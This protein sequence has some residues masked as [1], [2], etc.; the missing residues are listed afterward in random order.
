MAAQPQLDAAGGPRK[1]R[2]IGFLLVLFLFP[3][4]GFA[5]DHSVEQTRLAA[6]QSAFDAGHWD[7]AARLSRGPADQSTEFDFLQGLAL[8]R[9]EKWDD[10]K[11]AFETGAR[12]SPRD[13]RFPVE[14][15]GIAYKQKDFRTAKNRL[16]AV[17][18]LNPRDAYAR[19]F[20]ATIYFLEGNL[21]AALKYWNPEDKP[22]LR[23]VAFAPFLQLNESLRNRALAFNAPQILT[24]DALLTTES[25][26]DNL[27]IFS[28]RRTELTPADSG[29]YDLTLHLAER[30]L[31]GDSKLEGAI[32]L[33]SGLPYATLYPEMYNLGHRALNL[34][35][36]VRWDSQKR[37]LFLA[38]STPVF[39]DPGLRL[40]IYTD[41]RNENW[42]LSQTF[43]GVAAPLTDL[44]L[45][46]VAAGVEIHSVVNGRWSWSAGAET[47]SRN[48]RNVSSPLSPAQR[49]FFTGATSLASWLGAERTLA[50]IPE[51]RFTLDSS[52]QA[53]AGREFANP[54][55][56]FGTF[57]GS[58]TAHWL[59]CAHGDDY[60][61]HT[62]LRVGATA[63][64]ASLDELFQL[65][66]E[67]D[68]DLWLRGHAG[69]LGGRKG[70]APLG[71]RYFLANWELDKNI[72]ENGFFALKLGPFLDSGAIADSSGVFGSQRWQWDSGLQCKVRILG[73]VTAVFSYGR[74]LRGGKGVFYGTVLRAPSNAP[75]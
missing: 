46:R 29:N 10:A 60:E 2:V 33:L 26:L 19:E 50:R 11:L 35:S 40:R 43:F 47:A 66:V 8:S 23:T 61:T 74:N 44:N 67:R 39:G 65:G 75:F 54:L 27:D 59:P 18:L 53:R 34:T 13:S 15:A 36:L 4:T 52:A 55:G 17:L 69:T 9:L 21:E 72:Y 64:K 63:G 6:A 38:L 49:P 58:L 1:G 16:Q 42:N 25:R 7:E 57:R 45:R 30:N 32:S 5:Q 22:R 20:L 37:R 56:P 28:S 71:R 41:A 14:L 73:S 51:R 31:W 12:K 48:F 70:I 68:N 24:G 3:V 62:R